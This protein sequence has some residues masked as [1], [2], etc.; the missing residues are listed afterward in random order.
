MDLNNQSQISDT[1]EA[2]LRKIAENELE[3][4]KEIFRIL[5]EAVSDYAIF[6]LDK[7]GRIVTWNKGAQRFK[8]YTASEIIGKHFSIFY[9][10]EDK[11]SGK[12]EMELRIARE[13]GKYEDEG[14]RYKKD[15]S[16][17]WANVVITAMHNSSGELIGF[18]KI[19]RDLTERK[20]AEQNLKDLNDFLESK[21]VERTRELQS[22]A[23]RLEA[24]L[25]SRDE[26][27]TLAS[28]E[29]NTP[30]TALK[31][32]AQMRIKNFTNKGIEAFPSER[33]QKIFTDDV[34]QINRLTKLVEDMLDMSKLNS[35][36]FSLRK[37]KVNITNL[38]KSVIQRYSTQ[39][40]TSK[41]KITNELEENLSGH[42]DP[43]RYDQIFSN[44]LLNAIK[45]APGSEI[46]IQL[47]K[48]DKNIRLI[49]QD[50]GT[51]IAK[52]DHE[53][54]FLQF[55]RATPSSEVSG[56]GLGLFIVKEL[57]KAHNG[58]ITIE[59]TLGNGS[60]FTV[61]VPE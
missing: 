6:A 26:F 21:V 17:F 54:I 13:I 19:T 2:E 11:Q 7:E 45:Y 33:I 50:F 32:Q 30:L 44:L 12:P 25:Q 55:E 20:A 60:K 10:K 48:K 9:S 23:N 39:I 47:S 5:V 61:E 58:E 59:S 57:V 46:N 8:Q 53:R 36:T 49:V 42:V 3:N 35:G 1:S 51:G 28:H 4:S 41:N 52:E 14:W 24:A 38:V 43:V 40:E 56:L 15:G 29:L 18:S 31:L 37:E 16:R 27:I 22:L 34:R